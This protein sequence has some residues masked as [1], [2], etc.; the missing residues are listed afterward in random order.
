MRKVFLFSLLV[1]PFQLLMAGPFR[2]D[3]ISRRFRVSMKL[4]KETNGIRNPYRV[5][6]RQVLLIPQ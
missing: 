6:R 5:Q 1:V 2:L 4:L 3:Q